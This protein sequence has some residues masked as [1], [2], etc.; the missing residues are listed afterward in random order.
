MKMF[1]TGRKNW[2]FYGSDE[3]GQ[4]ASIILSIFS[5]CLRNGIE[6]GAYLLDVVGK[7][8]ACPGYDIEKLLPHKW[9]P[10]TPMSEIKGSAPTPELVSA[11]AG[12][13]K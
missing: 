4:Q 9:Q 2:Y 8:T 1:A 13:M 10:E 6:P 7:L 12:T 11:S 3:A 5:T